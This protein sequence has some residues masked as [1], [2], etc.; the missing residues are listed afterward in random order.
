MLYKSF[1]ISNSMFLNSGTVESVKLFLRHQFLLFLTNFRLR[2][3]V[4]WWRF[5]FIFKF[6][7]FLLFPR[8]ILNLDPHLP[9]TFQPSYYSSFSLFFPL[10]LFYCF[11]KKGFPFLALLNLTF[12]RVNL[13]TSFP[14][15]TGTKL[16]NVSNCIYFVFTK[17]V[18]I[19][20]TGIDKLDFDKI[21]FFT[22]WEVRISK[23]IF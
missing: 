14:F 22:F 8:T 6:L 7:L 2:R 3:W 21:Y 15:L 5:I 12:H 4:H 19:I 18:L 10:L 23:H 9:F 17:F 1:H 11:P 20:R 16:K 13:K